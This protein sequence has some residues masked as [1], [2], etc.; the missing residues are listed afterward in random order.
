MKVPHAVTITFHG[1]LLLSVSNLELLNSLLAL[2]RY[3]GSDY[4]F[5]NTGTK[6]QFS[7]LEDN[8]GISKGIIHS[9]I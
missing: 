9:E 5:L 6:M 1:F 2:S 8:S 3:C 4:F 7:L